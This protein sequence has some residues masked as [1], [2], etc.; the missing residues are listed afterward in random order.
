MLTVYDGAEVLKVT[1]II[2]SWDFN[3]TDDVQDVIPKAGE[4]CRMLRQHIHNKR[5][6]RSG[7]E[8]AL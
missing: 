2:V 8:R 7:L 6:I 1:N 5:E 3:G 4:N